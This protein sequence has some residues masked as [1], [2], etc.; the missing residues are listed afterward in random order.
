MGDSLTKHYLLVTDRPFVPAVDGSAQI[1]QVWL[2]A[3]RALGAE[4][5]VLSFNQWRTRWTPDAIDTLRRQNVEVHILDRFASRADFVSARLC[6]AANALTTGM[7]LPYGWQFGPRRGRLASGLDSLLAGRRFDAVIVQKVHTIGYLG[8]ERLRSVASKLIIDVHDCVPRAF[9]MT[10]HALVRLALWR[11]RAIAEP[12]FVRELRMLTRWASAARM[13]RREVDGLQLFDHVLFNVEEE[14]DFYVQN[15]L[16]RNKV[17]CIAW[18][19][20]EPEATGGQHIPADDRVQFDFG[21]IGSR[22]LFNI[23][24]MVHF[25]R[26]I[27]PRIRSKLPNAKLLIAGPIAKIARA[28]CSDL[29][30]GA[31]YVDWVDRTEDFYAQVRVVVV[32]MLW[33]TGRSVRMSEAAA[34]GAAIITTHVG[35]RGQVLEPDRDVIMRDDAASFADAAVNVSQQ[36]GLINQLSQSARLA[37]AKYYR[38]NAFVSSL[39]KILAS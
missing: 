38:Q 13:V 30:A 24:A 31:S 7:H 37:A 18:P 6:E 8:V 12:W 27:W 4:V 2:D 29:L 16:P 34:H 3:L 21:F 26:E 15:G 11:S 39:C 35:L 17:R 5:C 10:R 20:P 25:A 1:Y 22:A 14:A 32:P 28:E 23:D 36:P 9:S 19:T 33:G